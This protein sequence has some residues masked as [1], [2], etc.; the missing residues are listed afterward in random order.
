MS[1]SILASSD[2]VGPIEW[3]L[4]E[5]GL[6]PRDLSLFP[7]EP[8]S[9]PA[10]KNGRSHSTDVMRVWLWPVKEHLAL[11]TSQ[12]VVSQMMKETFHHDRLV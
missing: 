5:K 12:M 7:E 6:L 11:T 8:D 4:V 9:T 3:S 2:M 10:K 1:F